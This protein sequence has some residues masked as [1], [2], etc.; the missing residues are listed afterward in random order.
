MNKLGIFDTPGPKSPTWTNKEAGFTYVKRNAL[1]CWLSVSLHQYTPKFGIFAPI[2]RY[3][4]QAGSQKYSHCDCAAQT[5][6]LPLSVTFVSIPFK[7]LQG[8]KQWA[9]MAMRYI[10]NNPCAAYVCKDMMAFGI[11]LF[12]Y[13]PQLNASFL[14][15]RSLNTCHSA[16]KGCLALL[17]IIFFSSMAMQGVQYFETL[18]PFMLRVLL[19][20]SCFCGKWW[21]FA[22]LHAHIH[23]NQMYV[24]M[25][26]G[27]QN[28]ATV[29]QKAT[30]PLCGLHFMSASFQTIRNHLP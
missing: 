28:I 7:P 13:T 2:Y 25:W 16:A 1:K 22:Y 10:L 3:L 14:V 23:H 27:A 6:P 29:Q 9:C 21:L 30:W 8:P 4:G 11:S 19:C 26:A 17:W 24:S 12:Q 20:T 15:G 5:P 18:V